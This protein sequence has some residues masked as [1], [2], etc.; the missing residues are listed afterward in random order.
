MVGITSGIFLTAPA[1]MCA[2]SDRPT[3]RPC[4]I[5]SELNVFEIQFRGKIMQ[6]VFENNLHNIVAAPKVK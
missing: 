4:K 2:K 5:K 3:I 6:K 1:K